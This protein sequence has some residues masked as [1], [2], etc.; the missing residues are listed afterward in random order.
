MPHL[1]LELEFELAAA[2]EQRNFTR[3]AGSAEIVGR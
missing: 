1:F 2:A 3:A